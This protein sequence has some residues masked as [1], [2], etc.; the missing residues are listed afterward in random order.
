MHAHLRLGVERDHEA[1]VFGYGRNYF[2]FENLRP[3]AFFVEYTL[4]LSG[5][6]WRGKRNAAR[7][8]VRTNTVRSVDLPAEF[9][10]FTIL[11]LADLHGD[12]N[13]IAMAR[14]AELLGDLDFD[15]CVLTGDYRGATH[16]PHDAAVRSVATLLPKINSPVFGILGNHDT[17]R[18][19]PALEDLGIRMLMNES[20]T[21][22]RNG[23]AIY[24][25]GVDDPHFY[26]TDNI[27]QAA[28]GVPHD[29]FSILLAHTPEI[30]RRAAHA[31]FNLMLA[32]HTHGGQICLPGG[33]PIL[34][35]SSL[36]RRFGAGAWKHHG[37]DGY[38]S[39]GAGTSIVPVR[40]NCPPEITLHRLERTS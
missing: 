11:Q 26:R 33:I 10:G 20:E 15:L 38:T 12:M 29:S 31:E 17:V 9:D 16:G 36:P 23:A 4:K 6:Y 1:Q 2:H 37:M 30:Y 22:E 39:V 3:F 24:I 18:M 14:V 35:D 8:Q 25:V 21:I 40:F 19:V 34:L 28:A 27:E 7:V 5:M 13:A 32:G